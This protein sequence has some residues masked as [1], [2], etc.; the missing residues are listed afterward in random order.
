MLHLAAAL[1]RYIV[2]KV[3]TWVQ[4]HQM[5][6]RTL[7]DDPSSTC[8]V[9]L[10]NTCHSWSVDTWWSLIDLLRWW[11]FWSIFSTLKSFHDGILMAF[12]RGKP[13]KKSPGSPKKRRRIFFSSPYTLSEGFSACNSWTPTT[14]IGSGGYVGAKNGDETHLKNHLVRGFNPFEKY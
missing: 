2:I 11:H 3:Y 1:M 4:T 14:G 7:V 8:R 10:R 6:M 5:K 13:I 12:L 9:H